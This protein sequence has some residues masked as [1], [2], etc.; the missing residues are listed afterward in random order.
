[1]VIY[2]KF[3]GASTALMSTF[4]K[5]LFAFGLAAVILQLP[6]HAALAADPCKG[7]D[8]K[9]SAT[10]KADYSRLVANGL[11]QKVQ[12]SKISIINFMQAGTWTIVYA[13]VPVAD[14]GYFFLRL[15]VRKP[16]AEGSVGRNR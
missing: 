3:S 2:Q 16:R 12:P 9:L 1:M 10:R 11:D 5:Q 7:V 4:L 14:P 15:F 13:D 8:T 6:Q